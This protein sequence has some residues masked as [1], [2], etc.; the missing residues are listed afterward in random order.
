MHTY[1]D[2]AALESFATHLRE[3][4][5]SEATIEKYVRDVRSFAEW[6]GGREPSKDA[7][8]LWKAELFRRS[9]ALS[10]W[11]RRASA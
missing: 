1:L 6:L 11:V 5:K 10:T 3:D 9:A 2:A 4:E 7:A 8:L